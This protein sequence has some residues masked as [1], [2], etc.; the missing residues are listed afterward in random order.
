MYLLCRLIR[1]G[2][3]L[4]TYITSQEVYKLLHKLTALHLGVPITL[5]LDNAR[6]QKCK[7]V[8][9]T[10]PWSDVQRRS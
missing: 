3:G 7:L 4:Y 6:Y 5:F 2:L 8:M 1:L 10:Q 9:T